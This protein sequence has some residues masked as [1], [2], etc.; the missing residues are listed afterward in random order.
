V[1]PSRSEEPHDRLTRLCEAMT[2]ALEAH[3]EMS[4]EVKCVVFLQ[5]GERGGLQLHRYDDDSDAIV[6]VL[7]HLRAIFAANGQRLEVFPMPHP[8]GGDGA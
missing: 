2:D 3:P 4:D 1:K 5:D 6:D 8:I 7:M